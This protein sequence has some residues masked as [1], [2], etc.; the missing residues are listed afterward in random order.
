MVPRSP[1]RPRPPEPRA[2]VSPRPVLPAAQ[3]RALSPS[4]HCRQARGSSTKLGQNQGGCGQRQPRTRRERRWTPGAGRGSCTC[5]AS[6]PPAQDFLCFTHLG[7]KDG[8][9]VSTATPASFSETRAEEGPQP[10]P[11][12]EAPA[13]LLGSRGNLAGAIVKETHVAKK[14][15]RK[16]A[17]GRVQSRAPRHKEGRLC[18]EL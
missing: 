12:G 18:V 11:S 17:R 9:R 4:S 16:L 2:H 5:H 15:T 14:H 10:G 1:L 7:S 8:K 6:S 13:W 3:D